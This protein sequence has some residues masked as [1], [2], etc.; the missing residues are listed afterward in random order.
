MDG[1]DGGWAA[2]MGSN[3]VPASGGSIDLSIDEDQIRD[4]ERK[5]T[6]E[7]VAYF[8]IGGPVGEG[9][10]SP[11]AIPQVTVH[12]PLDV[13]GDGHAS[14]ID[15]LQVI[16]SLNANSS[17]EEAGIMEEGDRALDTNGD[18]RVSPIDALLVI[19]RLNASASASA[20]ETGSTQAT[21]AYFGDLGDDEED[22]IF[23]LQLL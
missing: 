11:R 12:D 6:T 13:N 20:T 18:G 5:H 21:D 9:E 22:A 17:T 16:N 1:G 7:Q 2:L 23:G 10:A 14:P 19:N 15:A 3:P 8:V 4:S